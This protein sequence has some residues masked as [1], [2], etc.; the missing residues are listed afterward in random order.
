MTPGPDIRPIVPS[1]AA[2][3][4][5]F[6]ERLSPESQRSR[7]FAVHPHL[8]PTEVER[9]T[10]VDHHDREALVAV[11]GAEIIGVG[12][13]DRLADSPRAEVAFVTRDDHQGT[14]IATA[15]LQQLTVTARRDGITRFVAET[16]ADNHHMLHVFAASGLVTG[17]SYDE[18]VVD[19]T[20]TLPPAPG[21][22]QSGP[23][24]TDPGEKD[25]NDVRP[26]AHQPAGR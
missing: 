2:A 9:F 10:D 4:V 14:G 20:M 21:S 13:Y 17:E 11:I 16:L 7:F 3:L 23:R 26:A 18:G 24:A 15:L 6:H 1:D 12:R 25:R 8:S 5:R 19:I 22:E